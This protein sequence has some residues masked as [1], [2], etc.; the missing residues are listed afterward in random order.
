MNNLSKIRENLMRD[1]FSDWMT[2]GVMIRPLHGRAL[3]EEFAVEIREDDRSYRLEAEMPGLKK[4]DIQVDIDGAQVTISAEIKQCDRKV[5]NEKLV[6]SERY[7][8]AV[9]RR[10]LLQSEVDS[11]SCQASYQDGL[12][13]LTLPKKA[14]SAAKRIAVH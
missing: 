14:S 3:P 6:Q 5:D 4:E 11:A 12:L 8:G 2:P 9:S 10:F 7:Y 13:T 1:F